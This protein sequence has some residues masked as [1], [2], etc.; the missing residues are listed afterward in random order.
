MLKDLANGVFEVIYTSLS[1]LLFAYILLTVIDIPSG[2][3]GFHPPQDLDFL[4]SV[5][6][7]ILASVI[8]V[9]TFQTAFHYLVKPET[10]STVTGYTPAS[11]KCI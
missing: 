10:N 4:A 3:V 5:F 8:C 6:A 1:L 9:K 7:G 2:T 11:R